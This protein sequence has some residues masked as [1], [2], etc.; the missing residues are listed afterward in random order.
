MNRAASFRSTSPR[1]SQ[2]GTHGGRG[3]S[4]VP[5]RDDAQLELAGEG[6]VA[7]LV[8]PRVE[9]SPVPVDPLARGLMG[10]V[11]GTGAQV[12]EEGAFGVDGPQVAHELDGPV[13]QVGAQVVAL[14]DAARWPHGVV[15]V[16]EGG[17]ELVGLAAVEAVPAVEPAG[18]GPGGAGGGHVGLVLGAQVPLA[19]GVGGVALLAQ[20]LREEAV[21]PGRPAP[22]ARDSP[23]A[24]SATRPMP[25]R[26]W[27]RPVSRQARDGEHSAVVWKL[28][29]R[30]PAAASPSM[31]GRGD[32]G[33]VAAELGEP[34][35]VEDD[36][37]HVGRPP[38]GGGSPAA[39]RAPNR[40]SPGRCGRGI[41]APVPCLMQHATFTVALPAAVAPPYAL[42]DGCHQQ[43]PRPTDS[44]EWPA[45]AAHFGDVGDLHLRQL[46][47]ATPGRATLT[48]EAGDLVVDY[49]KHRVTDE[50]LSLL[51]DLARAAGVEARRD[52]MF[53]GAHINTTEDRAVLHVALRM[54]EDEHARRRRPGRGGRRARGAAPH[55]R[56]VRP[57]PQRDVGRRHRGADPRRDQHRHRRVRPG[58][59][60]GHR[61]AGRLR[62]ARA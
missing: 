21:L 32:G 46:F 5:G 23:T 8:P 53:A 44:P 58:S 24:R 55:G 42:G 52:A 48:A 54:P 29:R 51:F 35:V 59:G 26:W 13:G 40:A 10:R 61:G 39:T 15:V 2:A 19:H 41:P 25:L 3:D 1:S 36:Q 14:L 49:S 33:A 18:Q 6:A 60:H 31:T 27:F 17:D 57:H 38:A 9:G 7:P 28:A 11:A 43:S 16:V 37:H 34:H 56:A 20:D 4:S 30:T 22:V 50:T 12:E 45:L 47:A 62:R